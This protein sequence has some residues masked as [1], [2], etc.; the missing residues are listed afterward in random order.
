MDLWSDAPFFASRKALLIG[1][2]T[3]SKS[4]I[5]VGANDT[6]AVFGTVVQPASNFFRDGSQLTGQSEHLANIQLG[7]EDSAN[8]SQQTLLISYASDRVTSRGAAGLP[9]ILESP[10]VT[11]DF[12]AR[13]GANLFGQDVEF[14]FEA[15]NLLRRDY[16][17][18][19]ER[20]GNKVYFN[21]YDSGVKFSFSVSTSF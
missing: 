19:Q 6:T 14:K 11:I 12:V 1:N 15:R 7:L 13:Q 9:D 18:F 20:E 10:G 16:R 21:R 3:W 17:E 2:Y 8:L 5:E 4:K